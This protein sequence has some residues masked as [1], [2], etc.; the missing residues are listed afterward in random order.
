MT[1]EKFLANWSETT[2]KTRQ[3]SLS[4]KVRTTGK[5]VTLVDKLYIA[6]IVTNVYYMHKLFRN[7]L[8]VRTGFARRP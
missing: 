1:T 3:R 8:L 4:L 6:W 2:K 5:R 7:K